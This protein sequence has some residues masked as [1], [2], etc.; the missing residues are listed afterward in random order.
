MPG[1]SRPGGVGNLPEKVYDMPAPSGA[2]SVPPRGGGQGVV[3]VD[4]GGG[5][6]G[7]GLDEALDAQLPVEGASAVAIFTRIVDFLLSNTAI[8]SRREYR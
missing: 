3:N 2:G 4:F 6:R 1:L 5:W 8:L 7:G